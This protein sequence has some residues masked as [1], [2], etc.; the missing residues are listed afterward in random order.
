M[1]FKHVRSVWLQF[2]L[3]LMPSQSPHVCFRFIF[4]L[5][6]LV[7][8]HLL[9]W[10]NW[11]VHSSYE[12]IGFGRLPSVILSRG[13]ISQMKCKHLCG[14]SEPLICKQGGHL[15][16]LWVKQLVDCMNDPGESRFQSQHK[17][18]LERVDIKLW[19]ALLGDYKTKRGRGMRDPQNPKD[20]DDQ[21][22]I[23]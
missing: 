10:G 18:Q 16:R 17:R 21:L 23:L 1:D 6:S 13:L 5:L 2:G 7:L 9:E 8:L 3:M 22:F 12:I 14:C 20:H 19:S 15:Q 11:K 4:P